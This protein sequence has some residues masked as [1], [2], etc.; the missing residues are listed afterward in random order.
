MINTPK[1]EMVPQTVENLQEIMAADAVVMEE[2]GKELS[3][4]KALNHSLY[5]RLKKCRIQY[6]ELKQLVRKHGKG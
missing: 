3:E 4:Y 5:Q 2:M 1:G 6:A